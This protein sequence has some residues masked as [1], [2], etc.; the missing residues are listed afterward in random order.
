MRLTFRAK[1][2]S[3]VAITMAAFISLIV[4]ETF[5]TRRI[6]RQLERIETQ[7]VPKVEL[8]PRLEAQLE[9]I[10]RAFQ[11]AVAL[12]DVSELAPTGELKAGFL[13]EIDAA[14]EAL[15]PGDA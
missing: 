14:H 12:H 2:M 4:T 9:R 5:A 11:D 6:E 7:Y 15:Q 13:R 8:E 10:Q 1:L 3:V